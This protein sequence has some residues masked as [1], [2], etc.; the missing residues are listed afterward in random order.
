MALVEM[1]L[2]A[3]AEPCHVPHPAARVLEAHV[4]TH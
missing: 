1:M 3:D 2:I 4:L